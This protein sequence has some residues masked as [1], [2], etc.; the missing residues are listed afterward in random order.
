[1]SL[2]QP[3]MGAAVEKFVGEIQFRFKSVTLQ[4]PDQDDRNADE[5]NQS[6]KVKLITPRVLLPAPTTKRMI[7]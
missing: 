6:N 3:Q 2:T 4:M 5:S 1:M 7:E